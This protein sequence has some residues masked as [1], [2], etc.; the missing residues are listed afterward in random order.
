MLIEIKILFRQF[1]L[2]KSLIMQIDTI[3][4]NIKQE[5]ILD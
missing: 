1:L 2:Y 3:I 5:T 4:M